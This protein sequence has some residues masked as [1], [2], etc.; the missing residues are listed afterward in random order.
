MD[1]RPPENG[2]TWTRDEKTRTVLSVGTK[3]KSIN[4]IKYLV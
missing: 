4:Q 2:E 3:Q 1:D